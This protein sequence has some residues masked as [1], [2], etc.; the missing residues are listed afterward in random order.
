MIRAVVHGAGGHM[1]RI[2]ADMIENADD[3]EL[4]AKVD[5]FAAGGDILASLDDFEGEADVVIDFSHHTSAP[6]L[7]AWA[8]EHKTAVIVAT[9]GHDDAEKALIRGA[10]AVIPVF[11]AANMSMGIALLCELAKKT[12]ALFP[13]ADIEI[14]ER[15]HNRK[16]DAPSGTAL[17][18]ADAIRE[19]RPQSR[20]V[21][22]R[23][24]MAKRE[25]GDIGISA[26]RMGNLPGTH[27]VVVMTANQSITLTHE[28]YNRALFADGAIAAARFLAGKPA[29]L[30]D[31]K[32]IVGA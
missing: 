2:L 14:I 31:M 20:V 32:D 16:I 28:V 12:A 8:A 24:G 27:E 5:K 6:A 3:F 9:T 23:S 11:Y 13:D 1:G 25:E 26:V 18:I 29:G 19:V 15:H 21:A 22:G 4:T 7:M 17:A 30:Y 10:A